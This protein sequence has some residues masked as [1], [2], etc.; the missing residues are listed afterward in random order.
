MKN[1][2]SA[3]SNIKVI[4]DEPLA[5]HTS[6]HIGGKTRFFVSVYSR[7]ALKRVLQII[8]EKAL[9]FFLIGAGTNVLFPDS[10]F[11]GVVL[12]LG[13]IFKRTKRRDGLFRCGGAVLIG[14]FLNESVRMGY[15]GAE[16]LAGIPGTIGGAVKGNAGAFGNAIGDIID[17][18]V[19]MDA[20]GE[21]TVLARK[22]L[23]LTYRGS[24]IENGCA[25]IAADLML[26]RNDRR[27]VRNIIEANLRRRRERQPSG[28][29]AGSFFKN[30]AGHA[31]G[32]LIEKCGLKG[33]SIGGAVV[34][35]KHANYIINRGGAQASDV[36]A[37]AEYVK[38]TV[39]MKTGIKLEEEVRLLN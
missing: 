34:S 35:E 20:R 4:T 23:G 10:G 28:Y 30:P 11:P 13:G 19:L 9:P 24:T 6:F 31:A 1:P 37:L 33:I 2:F 18:V 27:R 14:D 22:A 29:S 7:P 36:I 38:K 12:K 16:F 32:E 17:N 5:E 3:V 26:R 21:E 8:R 15:G 39:F 25:V